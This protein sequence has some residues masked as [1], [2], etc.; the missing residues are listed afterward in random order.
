MGDIKKAVAI[1][2][3]EESM[4][5]PTI[6]ASGKGFVADNI[7]KKASEEEVTVYEDEKLVDELIDVEIGREIPDKLYELVS[8]VLVFIEEVDKKAQ[9]Q[10][11]S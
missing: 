9:K 2:Y 6:L 10:Q 8:K 3:K 4:D 5:A 11:N 7:I 1:G